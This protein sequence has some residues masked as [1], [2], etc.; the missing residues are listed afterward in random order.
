ML[1]IN[2]KVELSLNWIENCVLTTS[3]IDADANATGAGSA[4]LKITGTKLYVPPVTLST[5]DSTKLTKQLSERFKRSVCWNKYKVIDNE[6]VE[7][8][9]ADDENSM[10][11]RLM[12]V[13]KELKDCLVLLMIIQQVIIKFLS[14]LSKN[15]S[16]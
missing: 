7:I 8:V 1:L 12:V 2:Y 3:A 6:E 15:I 16:F 5:E 4:I 13:I 11:E 9:R 10:R 14:S